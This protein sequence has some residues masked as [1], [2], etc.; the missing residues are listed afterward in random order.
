MRRF[1]E[2]VQPLSGSEILELVQHC[3]DKDTTGAVDTT[4]SEEEWATLMRRW[5]AELDDF[6]DVSCRMSKDK[7][8]AR[9]VAIAVANYAR[10]NKEYKQ[11]LLDQMKPEP[12]WT[13]AKLQD[14]WLIYGSA[15]GHGEGPEEA[16]RT[17]I[18]HWKDFMGVELTDGHL[19]N[20]LAKDVS[21]ELFPEDVQRA[22]A[23]RRAFGEKTKHR[24]W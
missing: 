2:F 8:F 3:A 12:T 23:E 18:H 13:E 11:F 16:R 19:K 1:E 21:V 22:Y 5:D 17:T 14:L 4:R 20:L 6:I 10:G 7:T 24:G 9:H 15:L